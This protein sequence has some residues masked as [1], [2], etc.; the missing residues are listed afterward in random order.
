MS[1]GVYVAVQDVDVHYQRARAAGAEI[2]RDIEDTDYGF[3][4]YTARDL[5]G[6]V[7]SFGSY[8]PEARP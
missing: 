4:E 8:L 2:V 6:L 5:D 3:R 7:W 1:Q